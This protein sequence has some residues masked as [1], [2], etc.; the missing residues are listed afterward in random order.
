[1]ALKRVKKILI[2]FT[3]G[4]WAGRDSLELRRSSMGRVGKPI[5]QVTP[6]G[7]TRE[8][9]SNL[10]IKILQESLAT[11]LLFNIIYIFYIIII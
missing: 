7:V 8:L 3:R 11:P 4:G 6:A 2:F 10:S 1:M 9:R 5:L